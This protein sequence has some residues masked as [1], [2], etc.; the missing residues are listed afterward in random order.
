MISSIRIGFHVCPMVLETRRIIQRDH[1]SVFLQIQ[2]SWMRLF[3]LQKMLL[4]ITTLSKF[5]F[6]EL[7]DLA[8][9][10]SIS[11]LDSYIPCSQ[12]QETSGDN[13]RLRSARQVNYVFASIMT[14][15]LVGNIQG[16]KTLRS[17]FPKAQIIKHFENS[18][19]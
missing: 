12:N 18:T 14:A 2:Y 10:T 8:S 5:G 13:V 6:L 15:A 4:V 1:Q 3:C 17:R 7:I 11:N 16:R 19:P 9:R